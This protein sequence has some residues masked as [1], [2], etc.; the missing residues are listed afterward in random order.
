VEVSRGWAWVV[1]MVLAGCRESV[2]TERPEQ[3]PSACVAGEWVGRDGRCQPAGLP[4]DLPCPPGEV[5]LEGGCRP[6]GPSGCADGFAPHADGCTPIL[7][8]S[9]CPAGT[10][11]VMGETECR[12]VA[13]CAPGAWGGVLTTNEAQFVDAQYAGSASDGSAARPWTSVQQAVDAALPGAV[14]ALAAGAYHENVRVSGKPVKIWGRCPDLVSIEGVDAAAPAVELAA[15]ASELHDVA[16]TGGGIGVMVRADAVLERVWIHETADR[17]AHV[18]G[19]RLEIV[20]SLIEGAGLIG[21]VALG[22]ELQ[23]VDSVVRDTQPAD[24]FGRGIDVEGGSALDM[25][26]SLVE[27]NVEIGVYAGSS[28]A[29]IEA[30]V[31]RDTE[32]SSDGFGRGIDIEDSGGGPASLT[33]HAS[34]IEGNVDA[35]IFGAG[36]DI[37]VDESVVRDTLPGVDGGFGSGLSIQLHPNSDAPSALLLSSSSVLRNR[38]AGISLASA[39]GWIDGSRVSENIPRASDGLAGVG[40]LVQDRAPTEQLPE[41]TLRA[42]RVDDN[43]L[44]GVILVDGDAVIDRTAICGTLP[45]SERGGRA[46]DIESSYSPRAHARIEASL[47]CNNAHS[48]LYAHTAD[49]E[50]VASEIRTTHALPDGDSGFGVA[51]VLGA[52]GT[53]EGALVEDSRVAGIAVYESDAI[54]NGVTVRDTR[55]RAI[56]DIFGDGILVLGDAQPAS[57][58][59]HATLVERSAR[60]GVSSFGG[61]ITLGESRLDCNLIPLAGERTTRPFQFQDLGGNR[62]GCGDAIENCRVRSAN[63]EPPAPPSRP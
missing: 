17:G 41:L 46:I 10:M 53:L 2:D 36:A 23:I 39:Q 60:A 35:G 18:E 55:A 48:S 28:D 57:A 51:I 27:R 44:C 30:S 6:A 37:S 58:A 61:D 32:M 4:R 25:E 26:R 54:L 50:F 3:S 56:D 52:K 31:V 20:G 38:E 43:H 9:P 13:P 49:F 24:R 42:S 59:L 5:E 15:G 40:I 22:A 29:R 7:P 14:V 8:A 33:L 19:G 12:E 62:C 1:L 45:A 16:V 47:L 11:A 63:L 21:V 34:V